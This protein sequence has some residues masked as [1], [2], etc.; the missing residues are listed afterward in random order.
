MTVYNISTDDLAASRG[1]AA[2]LTLASMATGEL[3]LRYAIHDMSDVPVPWAVGDRVRL[4]HDGQV[5]FSGLVAS[6][7]PEITA[8]SMA[9][10]VVIRDDWDIL[11][12]TIYLY[13]DGTGRLR[14]A[15]YIG[16]VT[17]G[18]VDSPTV[19]LGAALQEVL[20]GA[21]Y[22]FARPRV[23]V[24]SEI[25]PF[26]TSGSDTCASLVKGLARWRPD[27]VSYI[28][29]SAG[30]RPDLVLTTR[31][32]LPPARID[33]G[34]CRVQSLGSLTPRHDLIVPCAAFIAADGSSTVIPEGGDVRAPGAFVYALP[35][36][37]SKYNRT[38]DK[39]KAEDA[40]ADQEYWAGEG[41]PYDAAS[42]PVGAARQMQRVRGIK[43]PTVHGEGAVG[44]AIDKVAYKFW[45]MFYP[46]LRNVPMDQVLFSKEGQILREEYEVVE[47][48][49]AEPDDPDNP[50]PRDARPR[51][52]DMGIQGGFALLD[53]E[54]S[55]NTVNLRWCYATTYQRMTLAPGF[56]TQGADLESVRKLFA[57]DDELDGQD[58]RSRSLAG[59]FRMISRECASN[60]IGGGDGE[61]GTADAPQDDTGEDTGETQVPDVP[62]EP[63]DPNESPDATAPKYLDAL[64]AW[65]EANQALQWD[66]S[67]ELISDEAPWRY[68]GRRIGIVGGLPSWETMD[69]TCT[70][71]SIDFVTGRVVLTLGTRSIGSYDD[72]L[73][74]L[75]VSRTR[76]RDASIAAADLVKPVAK[77]V[78]ERDPVDPYLPNGLPDAGG[79]SGGGGGGASG[80]E[81]RDTSHPVA[82]MFAPLAIASGGGVQTSRPAFEVFAS[83]PRVYMAAGRIKY[84][85]GEIVDVAKTVIPAGTAC[86]KVRVRKSL[87][88]GKREAVVCQSVPTP[89]YQPTAASAGVVSYASMPLAT[90][91]DAPSEG[92]LPWV[93]DDDE[94]D[95]YT[96]ADITGAAYRQHVAGDIILGGIEVGSVE[97][98]DEYFSGASGWVELQWIKVTEW[99]VPWMS[100]D[101]YSGQNG[102]FYAMWQCAHEGK[103][104][105]LVTHGVECPPPDP[106][107]GGI[108]STG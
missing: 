23:A 5:V 51:N 2:S 108:I 9:Y 87:A 103:L 60:F 20:A 59:R 3:Q 94:G 100:A 26:S 67:I 1:T 25:V 79:G 39:A 50:K 72:Y 66:G 7:V 30:T 44:F 55:P 68:L 75:S 31:D 88:T 101:G 17:G 14:L 4:H 11:E 12:R 32:A 104:Y 36:E 89:K 63:T 95:I 74:R 78:A 64:K 99:F 40:D 45:C 91:G 58:A 47:N 90:A 33:I 92:G 53:G 106:N 18:S 86:V 13:N 24:S 54:L 48:E 21:P 71:V 77:E 96:I 28:D 73:T 15:D 8:S 46:D 69:A 105:S 27:M 97:E 61:T 76:D 34:R 35:Q 41:A 37:G 22:M 85:D 98:R 49:G 56:S 102:I 62:A 70:G 42:G 19:D 52:Y 16:R 82:P 65:W 43:V 81:E 80:G 84:P 6:A 57:D 107:Q 83:G 38:P 93:T 10:A 29:Y